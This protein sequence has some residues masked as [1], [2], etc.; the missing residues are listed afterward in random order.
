MRLLAFFFLVLLGLLVLSGCARTIQG[1][2]T[3][4][5]WYSVGTNVVQVVRRDA[6][7]FVPAPFQG[8]GE[9]VL[10]LAA[11]GLAAWNLHQ[12]KTLKELKNGKTPHSSGIPD[13]T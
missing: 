1:L 2:E 9:G 13:K 6:L 4:R 7:P 12:Q 10:A 5:A 3:E 11:A 8:I